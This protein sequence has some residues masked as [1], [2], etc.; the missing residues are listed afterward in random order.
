[1]LKSCHSFGGN[2]YVKIF[3]RELFPYWGMGEQ[4]EDFTEQAQSRK[5]V[6]LE[7]IK[8]VII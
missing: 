4:S 8:I 6:Q 7:D 1:M 3:V 5:L 2:G